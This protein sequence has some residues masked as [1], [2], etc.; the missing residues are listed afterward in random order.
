VSYCVLF[1]FSVVRTEDSRFLASF[2]SSFSL[3]FL[4]LR[5]ICTVSNYFYPLFLFTN[6]LALYSYLYSCN[7]SIALYSDLYSC[8]HSMALYSCNHSISVSVVIASFS[9]PMTGQLLS[10]S[11]KSHNNSTCFMNLWHILVLHHVF[12]R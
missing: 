3:P 10:L 9:L 5:S 11:G 7:H 12:V 6:P 8:N 4:G 2:S 1:R